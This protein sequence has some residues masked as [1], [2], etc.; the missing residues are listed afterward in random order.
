M[1]SSDDQEKGET[2][3][4]FT[5]RPPRGTGAAA[6]LRASVPARRWQ[7]APPALLSPAALRPTRREFL[8]GAGSL[9]LLGAAGCGSGG[10]QDQEAA[11]GETRTIEHKYGSTEISGTPERVLSLG[12]QE[13]DA[14]F[15]LGVTPIAVRYWYGDKNDVIFPWAEDEA[16]DADPEILNMPFG[17]LNFE[18]I[19]SLEPD[20]ILGVYAGFTEKEYQTLS[21]IAPTVAQSGK[22]IDFGVPWQEQTRVIGRALDREER[23]EELIAGVEAQFEAVREEHPEFDGA[24]VAVAQYRSPGEIGFFASQDPR[25]RFFTDLG[26]QF[27]K[28]LDEIAGDQFFGTISGERLDLLDRDVLVWNQLAFTEGGRATIENDPLVQKLDAA[29]EGRMVFIE[30]VLDDALQFNTVLS[31]PFLLEK[32]TPTLAA[33]VDGD[34][35]TEV[36]SES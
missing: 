15:A 18:K 32:V 6:R 29:K 14:I 5:T 34:P 7:L 25:V 12:F 10:E 30:G 13:H 28:E 21:E 4:A 1:H 11:S 27:P 2:M 24:S 9:L 36:N 19:A 16:G 3:S 8:I 23:A 26:F 33:A 35:D 17:E 22:H 20:L 31:L